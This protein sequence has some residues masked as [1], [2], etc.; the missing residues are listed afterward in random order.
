MVTFKFLGLSIT[1]LWIR[2]NFQ[3]FYRFSCQKDQIRIRYNFSGSG[4][5]LAKKFT[6]LLNIPYLEDTVQISIFIEKKAAEPPSLQTRWIDVYDRFNRGGYAQQQ[7]CL[8]YTL[9][10]TFSNKIR[11]ISSID[12]N[13][14]FN[15]EK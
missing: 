6:T 7:M 1:M 3:K 13:I 10:K 15:V 14:P 9:F 8:K 12:V 4:S 2:D 11:E 5:D